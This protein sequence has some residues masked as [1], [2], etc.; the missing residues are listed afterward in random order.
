M[1]LCN[2]MNVWEAITGAQH[3]EVDKS[4]APAFLHNI[5]TQTSFKKTLKITCGT[6]SVLSCS[7]SGGKS[8]S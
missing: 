5:T 2:V 4:V 8:G 3:N 1:V 7:A 6:L